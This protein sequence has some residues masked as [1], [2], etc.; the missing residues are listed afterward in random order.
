LSPERT[1][2]DDKA[3]VSSPWEFSTGAAAL[4]FRLSIHGNENEAAHNKHGPEY[5]ALAGCYV[6]SLEKEAVETWKEVRA[7]PAYD[8]PDA[9]RLH[10]PTVN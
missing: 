1:G 7:N 8:E 9:N 10:R 6:R 3:T 4:R 5:L 2:Q